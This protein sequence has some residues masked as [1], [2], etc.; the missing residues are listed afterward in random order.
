MKKNISI[1]FGI[2]IAAV[3]GIFSYRYFYSN[4]L[5]SVKSNPII[6]VKLSFSKVEKNNGK[7][8]VKIEHPLSTEWFVYYTTD[9]TEPDSSK[10]LY[11][12]PIY[13]QKEWT[14]KA[15][16]FLK[17]TYDPKEGTKVA[18]IESKFT[19][20]NKVEEDLVDS[21]GDEMTDV[22]ERKYNLNLQHN[23]ALEDTDLDQY[24][25]IVEFYRKTS[26]ID[27]ESKPSTDWVL[28]CTVNSS[29]KGEVRNSLSEILEAV[30]KKGTPYQ[31][32]EIMPGRYTGNDNTNLGD[33]RISQEGR[34]EGFKTPFM[35]ISKKGCHQT[36]FDRGYEPYLKK[37][38]E[39]GS[40]DN[41]IDLA[42]RAGGSS[43]AALD[44]RVII[45]GCTFKQGENGWKASGGL[46][47]DCFFWH[48]KKEILSGFEK[49]ENSVF[50]NDSQFSGSFISFSNDYQKNE[51][52]WVD[53][54][55]VIFSG[56]S[57]LAF[58]PN[59]KDDQ[60]I[61]ESE[62]NITNSQVELT[63]GFASS[64]IPEITPEGYI[65]KKEDF[66]HPDPYL[67]GFEVWLSNQN[68]SSTKS[69]LIWMDEDND[70]LPDDWEKGCGSR[71]GNFEP[72]DDNDG[73]GLTNIEEF[74]YGTHPSAEDIDI[75]K[76]NDKVEIDR[77][78]NCYFR[79]SDFDFM[80]DGYE[81]K[82]NLDP[83]R[84]D[85]YEDYDQDGFPN[86]FEFVFETAANDSKIVPVADISIGFGIG[87][88]GYPSE[89]HMTSLG[90]ALSEVT[91][92]RRRFRIILLKSL[93][94]DFSANTNCVVDAEDL[95]VLTEPG[96]PNAIFDGRND[97]ETFFA[98]VNGSVIFQNITIH[99]MNAVKK[100]NI[101]ENILHNGSGQIK[102]EIRATVRSK[103]DN[104]FTS[105][106]KEPTSKNIYNEIKRNQVTRS[107]LFEE[108]GAAFRFKTGF[109]RLV[110]CKLRSNKA[111]KKGGSIFLREKGDMNHLEL[112]NCEIEENH[113]NPD[114][115]IDVENE[116]AT[117]KWTVKNRG[118]KIQKVSPA[119]IFDK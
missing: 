100:E 4:N 108:V 61:R 58:F 26:P 89:Q 51:L 83:W 90:S 62:N 104:I 41:Q 94:F 31:I 74:K 70:D 27:M 34:L 118:S 44:A 12:K 101:S 82:N 57:R 54:K 32:I 86:V 81:I 63:K 7:E 113:A 79:D 110:N 6:E 72:Q 23:D 17:R 40:I 29:Q 75:D 15:A 16:A 105:L 91:L 65:F 20:A 13:L 114:F 50:L 25:N 1:I 80:E 98:E 56:T 107:D 115:D 99:G 48:H 28:D 96:K 119:F 45:I 33:F 77:G 30:Q 68:Q 18:S 69:F 109:H 53:L 22:Y 111:G 10:I 5:S 49:I 84:F 37:E 8:Y 35:M 39:G 2:V 46:I 3:V 76:A 52:P 97:E 93:E 92:S 78:T 11:Q 24:P 95:L 102:E 43:G 87:E 14:I 21:D 55:S 38:R 19:P 59:K 67:V 116:A 42:N 117:A 88:G 85:Q 112:I 66:L 60:W 47:K 106:I 73:D 71:L 103:F 36:I 9:G 64:K